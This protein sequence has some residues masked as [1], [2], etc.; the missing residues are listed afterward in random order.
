MRQTLPSN[1]SKTAPAK[2]QAGISRE[3]TLRNDSATISTGTLKLSF[4]PSIGHSET[5]WI[6][7][8][9]GSNVVYDA[10]GYFG[11]GRKH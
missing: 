10:S 6:F 8:D 2:S 3:L 5:V 9:H 7:S 11:Q 4:W 1:I